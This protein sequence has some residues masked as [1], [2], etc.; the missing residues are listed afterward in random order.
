MRCLRRL[1]TDPRVTSAAV[2][3]FLSSGARRQI[4]IGQFL[5]AFRFEIRVRF[6]RGIRP[7][8]AGQIVEVR[9]LDFTVDQ[10]FDFGQVRAFFACDQCERLAGFLHAPRAADAM[11]I[12]FDLIWDVVVENVRDVIDVDAAAG[13]VGGDQQAH[14]SGTEVAP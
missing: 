3:P 2:C 8:F 12:I 4:R 13:D 11:D 10:L 14:L 9:A 7:P 1:R 6:S 5:R